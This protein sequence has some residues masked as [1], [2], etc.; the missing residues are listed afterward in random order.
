VHGPASARNKARQDAIKKHLVDMEG[1]DD[2]RISIGF[3][4]T[5]KELADTVEIVRVDN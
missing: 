1:I 5:I 4:P 3:E 2:S